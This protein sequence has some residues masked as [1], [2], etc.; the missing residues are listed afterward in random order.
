MATQTGHGVL[1]CREPTPA[2]RS[3]R[4]R[5]VRPEV[6]DIDISAPATWPGEVWRGAKSRPPRASLVVNCARAFDDST[7]GTRKF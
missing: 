6:P 3:A 1:Y 4:S 5:G 2:R 7:G